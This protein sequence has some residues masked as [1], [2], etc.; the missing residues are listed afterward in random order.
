MVGQGACSAAGSVVMG[1]GGVQEMERHDSDLR[2]LRG[3]FLVGALMALMGTMNFFQ[4][5]LTVVSKRKAAKRH[6]SR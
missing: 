3:M 4:T 6:K 1:R 2:G 5:S